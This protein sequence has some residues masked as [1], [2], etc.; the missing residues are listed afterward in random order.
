MKH[1]LKIVALIF[2]FLLAA[3]D[4]SSKSL[5]ALKITNL[6]FS[7]DYTEATLQL[8]LNDKSNVIEKL[9]YTLFEQKQEILSEDI[10]YL[11]ADDNVILVELNEIKK[12]FS[13]KRLNICV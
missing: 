5:P 4:V 12:D 3:C 13:H 10:T 8:E 2:I 9:T 1:F 6:S 7:N 11:I